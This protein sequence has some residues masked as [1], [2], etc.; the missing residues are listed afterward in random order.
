MGNNYFY[1]FTIS[2]VVG[3]ALES[4]FRFGSAFI[5]FLLLLAC[6]LLVM[7]GVGREARKRFF[8]S[9]ILISCALGV[10]RQE[11]NNER[12]L[13]NM[14][15]LDS[16]V[17]KSVTLEGLVV[18]EVDARDAYTNVVF[19]VVSVSSIGQPSIHVL[20][21]RVRVLVRT[22]EYPRL[23]Y[24]DVVR[25]QGK[26]LV[27]KNFTSETETRMFDYRSYLARD[28]IFYQMLYP[29]VEVASQHKG[30]MVY[31]KLFALKDVLLKN[32][33][34]VIPEPE[35]S[36]AGGVLLGAKQSLG[37]E[38]LQ[39]F[40]ETGV[41]H[42]VVLSGYNI[43]IVASA[44]ARVA[45]SLSF[46]LRLVM[47]AFGIVMFAMLVG[48]GATVVRATIM[49]LVVIIARALGRESSALRV[50]VLAGTLMVLHNPMILF[51]DVS[52]QL[53]FVATLALVVLV[54]ILEKYFFGVSRSRT[55]S[56]MREIFLA[57]VATQIF[58][59]PLLLYHMGSASVVGLITNLIVLPAVPLAMLAALLV[60]CFAWVPLLGA[61]LGYISYIILAYIIS[62]VELFAKVP[63]GS[64]HLKTFPLTLLILSYVALGY[65]VVKN[66]PRTTTSPNKKISEHE[67]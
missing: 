37:E 66:F 54:P 45:G 7:H 24:G 3:V 17:G 27:P 6:M 1:G 16:L 61:M 15:V 33:N 12:L 38:L 49:V 42:I 23:Q 44:L 35:A 52:F 4:L 57:T 64:L 22:A 62:I 9:C 47:S 29:V 34:R 56:M 10:F 31:E 14:H 39:K 60:A 28:D 50:L 43:A 46:T 36:L 21:E 19:E 11:F 40:R 67:F 2:F 48:G 59:L 41:V 53:S 20:D 8:V 65:I 58:V 30:N 25:V 5:F 51:H 26:M 13:R 32:I 55:P 63:Y 18:R